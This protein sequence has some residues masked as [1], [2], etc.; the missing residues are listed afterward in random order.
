M[1]KPLKNAQLEHK[2][3]KQCWTFIK[4]INMM[5]KNLCQKILLVE[6]R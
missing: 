4:G 6:I 1:D 3:P 5:K 2:L